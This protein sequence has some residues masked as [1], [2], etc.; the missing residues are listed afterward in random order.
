[1]PA[2][3]AYSPLPGHTWTPGPQNLFPKW[4]KP[5]SSALF[6]RDGVSKAEGCEL[7]WDMCTQ[8]S[9][10]AFLKYLTLTVEPGLGEKETSGRAALPVP[11]HSGAQPC[12]QEF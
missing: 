6:P 7:N 12:V 9:L 11:P 8:V 10:C 4:P 5:A 1:M 3:N 2:Q